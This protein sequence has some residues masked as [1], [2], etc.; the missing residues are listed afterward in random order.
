M[1]SGKILFFIKKRIATCNKSVE[2]ASGKTIN[3]K[4]RKDK[5]THWIF[6]RSFPGRKLK[7][8]EVEQRNLLSP[9]IKEIKNRITLLSPI[10]MI[11]SVGLWDDLHPKVMSRLV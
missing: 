2:N 8:N 10:L 4:K 9:K 3:V 11:L 6:R 7:N 1:L 5:K